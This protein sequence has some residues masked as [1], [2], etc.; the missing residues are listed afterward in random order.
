MRMLS[1]AEKKF[2]DTLVEGT[3]ILIVNNEMTTRQKVAALKRAISGHTHHVVLLRA[4]RNAQADV[5][6]MK[7]FDRLIALREEAASYLVATAK[8]LMSHDRDMKALDE[9]PRMFAVPRW[10]PEQ[11]AA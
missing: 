4:Q 3:R 9:R 6:R 11:P 10:Q 1:S 7:Q 2:V 8:W 5:T